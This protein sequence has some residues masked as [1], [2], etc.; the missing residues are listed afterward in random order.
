ME[1]VLPHKNVEQP[2]QN[3]FRADA[4]GVVTMRLFDCGKLSI[5][6]LLT[7]LYDSIQRRGRDMTRRGEWVQVVQKENL[8][9]VKEITIPAA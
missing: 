9:L 8:R 4:N 3:A 2:D 5:A 7:N 1:P 6:V